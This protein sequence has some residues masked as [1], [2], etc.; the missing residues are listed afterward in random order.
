MWTITKLHCNSISIHWFKWLH[1]CWNW[2]NVFLVHYL[3]TFY[4]QSCN[5]FLLDVHYF[6]VG[7]Y[8]YTE[9]QLVPIPYTTTLLYS[10]IILLFD[11]WSIATM[12]P[13]ITHS[14]CGENLQL[15]N[16]FRE[17]LLNTGMFIKENIW[18]FNQYM[19]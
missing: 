13:H 15:E 10:S 8:D 9:F 16:R 2:L 12:L 18:V 11:H 5:C 7:L 19:K 14:M 6:V 1:E 4:N 17:S 3:T